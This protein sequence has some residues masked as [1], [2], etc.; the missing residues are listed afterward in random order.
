MPF[1]EYKC[2]D[3][4]H[5]FEELIRGPAD[6]EALKCPRCHSVNLAKC[7]S[8]FGMVTSGGKVVTSAPGG[9]LACSTC[10]KS[11]CSTCR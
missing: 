8:L 1:Y 9:G 2:Q 7:L 4:G 3:C 11:D 5:L 10:S 6:I